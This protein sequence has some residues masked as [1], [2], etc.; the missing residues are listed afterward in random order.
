ML[1]LYIVVGGSYTD[2]QEDVFRHKEQEVYQVLFSLFVFKENLNHL[3]SPL[4]SLLSSSGRET[5]VTNWVCHQLTLLP[6]VHCN[7]LV[8][9]SLHLMHFHC[10]RDELFCI[11][12]FVIRILCFH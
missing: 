5:E 9:T 3:I 4:P 1:G 2:I 12:I 11:F 7:Y 6:L 10:S 8:A